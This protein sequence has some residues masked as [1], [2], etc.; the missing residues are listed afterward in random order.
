MDDI[1]VSKGGRVVDNNG[2]GVV[3]VKKMRDTGVNGII[4]NGGGFTT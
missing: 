3:F 4:G 2:G 1:V